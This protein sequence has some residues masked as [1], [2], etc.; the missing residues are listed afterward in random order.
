MSI[1]FLSHENP[2]PGYCNVFF[3]FFCGNIS[4]HNRDRE[5]NSQQFKGFI[6]LEVASQKAQIA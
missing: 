6:F 1:F 3:D 2:V 5:I 4:K